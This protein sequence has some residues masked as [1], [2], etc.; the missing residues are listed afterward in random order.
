MSAP[1]TP[2][3][4]GQHQRRT[5]NVCVNL[6]A[7]PGFDKCWTAGKGQEVY[8]SSFWGFQKEQRHKLGCL[9]CGALS[10]TVT[11]VVVLGTQ[12]ECRP[13]PSSVRLDFKAG[14]MSTQAASVTGLAAQLGLQSGGGSGAATDVQMKT[15]KMKFA[16][17]IGL[18]QVGEVSN[19][20]ILETVLNL[21]SFVSLR[22]SQ[23]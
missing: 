12:R 17:L 2:D 22:Y 23:L 19:R 20:D 7:K 6:A 3:R 8:T 10:L 21:V 15:T 13:S 14:R 16:V 11:G 5:C 4:P 18:I 1:L 9:A